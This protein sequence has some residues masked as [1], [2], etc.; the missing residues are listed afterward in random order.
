MKY[1]QERA[2]D[3]SE[4]DLDA[5]TCDEEISLNLTTLKKES[6]KTLRLGSYLVTKKGTYKSAMSAITPIVDRIDGE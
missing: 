4:V 6:S 1:C 2:D 3:S 5:E